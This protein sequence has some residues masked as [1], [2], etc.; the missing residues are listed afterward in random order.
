MDRVVEGSM[1]M[2][3]NSSAYFTTISMLESSST[4]GGWLAPEVGGCTSGFGWQILCRLVCFGLG[5][6]LG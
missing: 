6:G 4:N 5:Y 1:Y 2:C 3:W